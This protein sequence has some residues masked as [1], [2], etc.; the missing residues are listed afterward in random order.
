VRDAEAMG[1]AVALAWQGWGRVGRN[2][3]VGAVLLRDGALVAEAY[4]AIFGGPHAERAA[5]ASAGERARG[6]DLVVTLEPCRHQGKTP[7]CVDAIV[8]AGVRRVVYGTADVDQEARGGAAVLRR[9]GIA[10]TGGVLEGEVRAQNAAFFHRHA[11]PGRPWVALKLA[12]SLDGRIADA[13][14]RSRWLTGPPARDW[15]QLLRAGFEAIA[16]GAGTAHTDDPALTVRGER[17]PPTPPVRVV[18]DRSASLAVDSRLVRTAR[19]LP[20]VVLAERPGPNAAALRKAGVDVRVAPDAAGALA[21]LGERGVTS[22]LVEGGG[23]LAGGLLAQGLVDRIYLL[24]A[25]IFLGAGGRPAFAGVPDA[26][27]ETVRRWRVV[28]RHALGDDT[29]LVLDR[30]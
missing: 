9:A 15:V 3:M 6:A 14:G 20:T 16:V 24:T 1:R 30:P 21:S 25:P 8:A 28:G 19:E 17:R 22:L 4:H 29:L 26:D 27:I 10:V 12:V 5:L 7:P 2:P 11:L 13:R 23:M 18:F